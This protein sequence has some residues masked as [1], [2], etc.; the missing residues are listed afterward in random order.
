[1]AKIGIQLLLPAVCAIIFGRSIVVY[2]VSVIKIIK[3]ICL[4]VMLLVI[5]PLPF[6]WFVILFPFFNYIMSQTAILKL[7]FQQKVPAFQP[8]LFVLNASLEALIP[9]PL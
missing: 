3:N 9:V 7:V 1:M 8:G 5:I 4:F 2:E 6:Q